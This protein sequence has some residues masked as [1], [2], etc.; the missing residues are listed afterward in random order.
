MN[1][2]LET[3]IAVVLVV[4][5]FSVIT[6]VFQELIAANLEL[7]GKMLKGSIEQLLES[8]AGVTLTNQLYSHPQIKKLHRNL[9]RIP[10][11]ISSNNFTTAILD[12]VSKHAPAPIGN[13]LID[14]KAGITIYAAKDPQLADWLES[15]GKVSSTPE[16]LKK[17]MEK[18]YEDYMDRVTGWYKRKSTIITRVIAVI[19]VLAF[20]VDM[21][22]IT[23]TV[24]NNSELKARLNATANDIVANQQLYKPLFE[25]NIN[26]RLKQIEDSLKSKFPDSTQSKELENKLIESREELFRN[27]TKN[28]IGEVDSLLMKITDKDLPLGWKNATQADFKGGKLLWVLLGWLLGAAA[29]SMGAPFWFD[30]LVKLVNVR[31]AGLKPEEGPKK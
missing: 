14:F 10:S 25:Q 7:R 31:K 22:K 5:I 11:Y 8:N 16:D 27:Y 1:S 6:Y 26:T 3:A 17:N 19:V 9:T 24:H 30:L 2:Y 23:T 20:N 21:I 4:L 13:L 29:I 15:L 18:W 28:R 12:I